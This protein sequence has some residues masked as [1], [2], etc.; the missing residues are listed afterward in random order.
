MNPDRVE[1]WDFNALKIQIASPEDIR[2]W[3]RGEVTKAETINYR[4]Q[5]PERDGLFCERIFGPV[6]DYECSCGKYKKVRY[7]GIVCD[8]CGVEVT[9]SAVRR[10]RMGHIELA[11]PVVHPLFYKVPPSKIGKL[12]NLSA[13]QIESI[14]NYEAYVV[15][16][17]GNSSLKRLS[18]IYDEDEYHEATAKFEALKAGMGAE[19]LQALLKEIDLDDLSAELKS[20]IKHEVSKRRALLDRLKIVE[21][22]RQ[23]DNQVEWMILEVIPVI[24]PDLRPLV[25]LEGGRYAT[26]DINDLYKR[27]IVRNNRLKHLMSIKTPEIILKNE[28]RMLQEAINALFDN[29]HLARP[30]RGR[31]NRPLKSLSETLRGKQGRFR[32]NLLGKRVDYS[33]RS[34]IV[35]D[36]HLRLNQCSLPKEMAKELFRPVVLQR[37]EERKTSSERSA[38]E[39]F[40]MEAPEMWEALEE[41]VKIHPI[42]LNRAPTLHRVSVEAFFPRLWE[43]RAIGIH[44]L[45]CPPFNADFDGDTMSVHVPF[46]P[47]AILESS[48]L[49]LSSN[50]ILSPADGKPLMVPGQDMVLGIYYLTKMR[51]SNAKDHR[52]LYDS[53]EELHV[54][55]DEGSLDLFDEI[56]WLHQGRRIHTTLGRAFLNEILPDELRFVNKLLNKKGIVNLV[57]RCFKLFGFE[58]AA[59]LLDSLKYLGFYYATKSSTS[60]GIDDVI[61]PHKKD[62]IIGRAMKEVKRYYQAFEKGVITEREKYNNVVNTWVNISSELL[63]R[64]MDDLTSD[65]EGFNSLFML[66]DS[67]ARGS[68]DQAKQLAAMRGLMSRPSRRLTG[69]EV[70]E[71]PII[72]SFKNGLSVIEYFLSTHGARKGLT[73]TALKTAE[74]GYLT[75]RLVDVSQDVIV[76]EDDCGT[77]L[78]EEVSALR[79]GGKVMESL[80]E[81]I[82]GRIALQTVISPIT[83]ETL[84]YAGEE[85]T[86]D[87]AAEIEQAGIE[88]VRVRSVLTCETLGGVCAQCYGRNPATGRM[89]EIGEAVGIMAAQSIGEP[90]TQLTLRTFHYGG[91]AQRTAEETS[92]QAKFDGKVSFG[93]LDIVERDDGSKVVVG[94]KGSMGL[95]SEKR[96]STFAVP[97]GSLLRVE[98]G[99]E[100]SEGV[101]LFEWEPYVISIIAS[102]PGK[103]HYVDVI[104]GITLREDVIGATERKQMI[105]VE[106]REKRRHPQIQVKDPKGKILESH[107]LPAGAYILVE[108]SSEI[109]AGETLAK[110]QRD[111]GKTTDITGGLPRVSE[112]F[113]AKHP[114]NPAIIADID[115]ATNVTPPEEGVRKLKVI[116]DSGTIKEYKIPYAKYLLVDDGGY[117]RAGDKLCEGNIDPHDILR[118]KG[119]MAVM[120]YLTNE[121]QEVYRMQGVKINDKHIAL[122]V[123]QM[124]S[125][126][127][128]DDPG[129]SVFVEGEIVE[130]QN[131]QE[132]NDKLRSE[133]LIPATFHPILLGI[134]KASLTTDSFFAAASFQET[135]RVLSRAAVE[136]KVDKLTGLKEN[137]IVGKLIPAGTGF[138]GFADLRFNKKEESSAEEQ[139]DEEIQQTEAG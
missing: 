80:S 101:T 67:G 97:R 89:V 125:K 83:D 86:E 108:D 95:V 113:E 130:K 93:K 102:N 119:R 109:H 104:P 57:D 105:I 122:I 26:S 59:E 135:T 85:I 88:S 117:V 79:E 136:G 1:G 126:V 9:T 124:L 100:V 118:V 69:E 13:G 112:L 40:R 46:T 8:R 28:K 39:L 75:R 137:V 11:I 41:I 115:G 23:S 134:T 120:E 129:D 131:I 72:S 2:S 73:D 76:K 12:L 81:R 19:S 4:T 63:D 61:E 71:R 111:I 45:V 92:V 24:P 99:Q 18:L 68:K 3:S 60:I 34:V 20:R 139:D 62:K 33:G 17:S 116:S 50:N 87:K 103:V 90:G 133:D 127:K 54:A 30:V 16:E 106:D 53:F 35:V 110:F 44:P 114:K 107:E 78:G 7:R 52:P 123:R 70:I 21:A 96:K 74:A 91:V 38:K 132:T 64:M 138:K 14:I 121:I 98:D 5:K 55:Y 32:R 84:V 82:T 94:D 58:R 49:L 31:G 51:L 15:L 22:F 128:I 25:A 56:D 47:E 42:L 29:E 48:V 10:E 6:K 27:V 66:I 65:Q 37:L 36:P 43:N 77:I